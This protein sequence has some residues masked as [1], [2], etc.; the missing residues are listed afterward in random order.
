LAR[1]N[2]YLTRKLAVD[3]SKDRDSHRDFIVDL[4]SEL[5]SGM[6]KEAPSERQ[7]FYT[8]AGSHNEIAEHTSPSSAVWVASTRG[9]VGAIGSPQKRCS[10]VA[11]KQFYTDMNCKQRRC[12]NVHSSDKPYACPQKTSTCWE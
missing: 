9:G 11:S 10:V 7:M 3:L 5:L 12:V 4:I 8:D 2:A 6:W 1:A